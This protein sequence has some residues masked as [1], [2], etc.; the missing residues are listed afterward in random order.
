[1]FI[2]VGR[3]VGVISC[4]HQGGTD[5]PTPCKFKFLWITHVKISND[6]PWNPPPQ[7]NSNDSQTPLG[8]IFWIY[9]WNNDIHLCASLWIFCIGLVIENN[10]PE[11]KGQLKVNATLGQSL[12]LSADA[13]DPDGDLVTVISP[14]GNSTGSGTANISYIYT[15]TAEHQQIRYTS[16]NW[17]INN[18][19]RIFCIHGMLI[20]YLT[21]KCFL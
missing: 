8:K 6:I 16:S 14:D 5:P 21:F 2:N 18:K 17:S 3:K 19:V 9:A 11:I 20:S 12:N 7:A 1:M 10:P 15:P 4:V 13:F